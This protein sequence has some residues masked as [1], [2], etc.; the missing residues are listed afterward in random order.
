MLRVAGRMAELVMSVQFC[1]T[2]PLGAGNVVVLSNIVYP[3][4]PLG[5]HTV[6]VGEQ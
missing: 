4:G 2:T 3:F 1:N 6:F 5:M